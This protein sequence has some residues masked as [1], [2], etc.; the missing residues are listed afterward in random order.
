M[1]TT[2]GCFGTECAL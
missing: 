1:H 2:T